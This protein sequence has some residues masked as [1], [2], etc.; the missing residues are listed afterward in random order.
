MTFIL[1]KRSDGLNRFRL[2]FLT[3]LS[4]ILLPACKNVDDKAYR[5]W[6]GYG[7]GPDQSKYFIQD[8]ITKENVN[9]LEVAWSYATGDERDYQCNPI[10]VDSVMY[11]MAK[12]NSLVALNAVTGKEIWIHANLNGI[13]RRGITYWE[14][15][16]RSDRRLLFTLRNSLQAIDAVTGKAILNF[17]KDGAVDLRQNLGIDPEQIGRIASHTPGTVYKDIIILGSSP[18]ESYLSTPGHVRAYNVITGKLEWKFNTIP[19]PGEYGYDT[20]PPDAYKYIGGVNCWGEITVDEKSGI[21]YV[22]LGSP[23][24]DY[25]G[26]DRHGANLFG[27]CL[28]ALDA[29]TGKRIWHYQTVH[30]DL[31]DYDLTAAPQLIRVNHDGKNIDAVA[32]ATKQGFMF[33]FDRTNGNP[34]WPIEERPVPPSDMPDE[35]AWPTQPFPTVLKPFNRQTVTEDDIS[36]IFLSDQELKEWK[37]R[38][39]KARKGLFTPPSA[40][41]TIA[42]PGAVGGANWGN[43]ASNPEKGLVYVL[44]QDYPSFYKLALKP[45]PIPARFLARF[46]SQQAIVK[47]KV[48]YEAF[49]QT[50][51]GKD[52]SGTGAAPSLLGL[53]PKLNETTIH[54]VVMQGIGR[55]PPVQHISDAD[56]SNITAY[57]KEKSTG[58]AT[59]QK[60]E[61]VK[62]SGPVVAAGGAPGE[63]ATRSTVAFSMGGN[64]YPAG[65][66]VPAERYYTDYG[67]GRP[68]ILNPPWS[69]ITAYDMNTGNIQWTKPLG[70]EPQAV[71]KGFNNTGVPTGSQ[72]NGIIV[73]SNGLLF[74]TVTNGKIYAYDASN[75]EILWTGQ[76]PLGIATMPSMYEVDGRIFI[77]VNATTPQVEGWNLT[78]EQKEAMAKNAKKGGAYY[79]YTLPNND[80]K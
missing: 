64:A 76:T 71:A 33:A 2:L 74:A 58:V 23:T 10:I 8:Q 44:T 79:V 61:E 38:V 40:I 31:W 52:L 21:A 13:S 69:S 6:Q 59:T 16:D 11:V 1:M 62:I 18:G 28:L 36:P 68:F 80:N 27:N 51:H 56:V 4:A 39:A 22:P 73:T 35:K 30:H 50:C 42:M 17:G 7:S 29:K 37:E 24:Y 14:N 67:L 26:A 75:G 3:A 65:V 48:A 72:R 5:T 19:Q 45:P 20:W 12:D 32:I 55:M 46:E 15:A 9:Q 70:E 25:Y 47:G 60:L 77:V 54:E 63:V 34:L 78:E 49:C 66:K 41:E 43:T 53:G 57:L